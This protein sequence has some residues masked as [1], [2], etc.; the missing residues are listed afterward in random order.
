MNTAT[1]FSHP[2]VSSCQGKNGKASTKVSHSLFSIILQRRIL[3]IIYRWPS[4]IRWVL[5]LERKRM[6]FFI[7]LSASLNQAPS[8]RVVN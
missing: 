2:S 8:T 5:P 3:A 4:A 1:N 6:H 7:L